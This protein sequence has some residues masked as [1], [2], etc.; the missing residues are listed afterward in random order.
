MLEAVPRIARAKPLER[1]G[2][3]RVQR[4]VRLGGTGVNIVAPKAGAVV[5]RRVAAQVAVGD[6]EVHVAVVVEVRRAAAPRPAGA[7]DGAAVVR[8]AEAGL[9]AE[10]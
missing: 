2:E 8:L 1:S 9:A 4:L 3:K 7:G 10:E 6:V 5:E